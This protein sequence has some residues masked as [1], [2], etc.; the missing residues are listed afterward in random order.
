MDKSQIGN[1]RQQDD[2]RI[3]VRD[4]KS[5]AECWQELCSIF[6][7]ANLQSADPTQLA[8][9]RAMRAD[10]DSPDSQAWIKSCII[11][12]RVTDTLRKAIVY[13]DLPIWRVNDAREVLV[14]RTLLEPGNVR[15]G[16]FKS[17][18]RP[19]PDMQGAKLWVKLL[20]WERF[21]AR[22][23]IPDPSRS[24]LPPA[25]PFVTLSEAVAWIAFGVSMDSNMVDAVLSLDSYGEHVPQVAIKGAVARLTSLAHGEKIAMQGKY[26]PSHHDEKC[27]LL[28]EPIEAHKFADYRQFNHLH[29]ALLHGEGVTWWRGATE[30]QKSGGRPDSFIEVRVNRADLLREFGNDRPVARVK[31]FSNSEIADW[32]ATNPEYTDQKTARKAFMAQ[33]RAKGL[34]A[35][36]ENIW[37][38]CHQHRGKGRPAR[39]V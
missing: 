37:V 2:N 23:I 32:I 13:G 38:E 7:R 30:R 8:N 25:E 26:R 15:H 39:T 9:Y 21:L 27:T 33:P 11:A 22:T 35:T 31:P 34:S 19:E 14:A 16:I 10:P 24:R 6:T 3:A 18:E 1:A 29:D 36:F 5:L 4:A 12:D 20:D 17:H 28:T